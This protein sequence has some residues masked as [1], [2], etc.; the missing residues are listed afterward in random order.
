MDPSRWR[1]IVDDPRLKV[2]TYAVTAEHHIVE[3]D[4]VTSI[5][6]AVI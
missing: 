4:E 2:I 6:S 1:C 5:L 3:V